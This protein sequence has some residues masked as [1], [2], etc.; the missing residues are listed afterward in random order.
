[1]S[2]FLLVELESDLAAVHTTRGGVFASIKIVSGVARVVDIDAISQATL[3]TWL[4][5]EEQTYE[6][7]RR[8]NGKTRKA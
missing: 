2:R 5:P 8:R 1:M 3:D 4:L 6:Y 7:Q